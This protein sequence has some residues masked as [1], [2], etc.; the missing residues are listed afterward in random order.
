MT[1]GWRIQSGATND[2]IWCYWPCTYAIIMALLEMSGWR[3]WRR[4][5]ARMFLDYT[6][7]GLPPPVSVCLKRIVYGIMSSQLIM[8]KP[9][10]NHSPASTPSRVTD[11][12]VT[13]TKFSI[14]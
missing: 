14:Y 12:L 1:G 6:L 8:C 3:F 10:H 5:R 13:I 4:E 9:E 11:K 2:A 7:S